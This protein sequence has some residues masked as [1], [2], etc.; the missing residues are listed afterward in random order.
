MLKL[1]AA[2]R[3]SKIYNVYNGGPILVQDNYGKILK[4]KYKE[5][6]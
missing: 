5:Q 3:K 1:A 6:K 2:N 4:R